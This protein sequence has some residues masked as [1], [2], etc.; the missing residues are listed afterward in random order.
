MTYQLLDGLSLAEK[1]QKD[2]TSQIASH[3]EKPGLAVILVGNNP[4]SQIYV[5]KKSQSCEA[6]G[7]KS[8]KKILDEKISQ[9][10]LLKEIRLLNEDTQVHGILVQQPLPSHICPQTISLHIDPKKDVDGFHP[11]NEIGRAHI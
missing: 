5:N 6:L 11:M 2:L 1:I 10:D 4:A 8:I 7:M 3:K 9:E